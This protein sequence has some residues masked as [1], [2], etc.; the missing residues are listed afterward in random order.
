MPA[1]HPHARR[2]ELDLG[3]LRELPFVSYHPSLPHHALQMQ[4][5]RRVGVPARTIS[6]SSVDAILAFVS[7]GL[8]FSVV[9]WLDRRGPELAN[10]RVRRQRGPGTTFPI[11]AIWRR[12]E[13]THPLVRALLAALP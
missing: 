1:D 3:A 9:P 2:R 10:V 11:L 13:W 12:S 6:A 8:G 4:A 5:V 7:A